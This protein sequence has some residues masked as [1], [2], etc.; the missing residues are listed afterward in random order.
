[1][2]QNW[3][4]IMTKSMKRTRALALS[5]VLALHAAFVLPCSARADGA[6][7]RN[8]TEA[9]GADD[10]TGPTARVRLPPPGQHGFPFMST[11]LDL[12]KY[13][14]Q[15]QE[16]LLSGT[17]TAYVPTSLLGDDGRWAVA[18]NPGVTAPYTVR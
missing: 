2:T 1:M 6:G 10:S 17:A 8:H 14:Y 15:E 3:E 9:L 5:S 16:F 4:N 12:S 13:G 18:P 11:K 7:D